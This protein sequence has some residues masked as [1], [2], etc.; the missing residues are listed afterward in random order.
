MLPPRPTCPR[1]SSDAVDLKSRA[2]RKLDQE[3][4]GRQLLSHVDKLRRLFASMIDQGLFARID[5]GDGRE[6]NIDEF[7]R[8]EQLDGLA[9]QL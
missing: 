3:T 7:I 2:C 4:I 5:A 6:L 9:R 1:S 8:D